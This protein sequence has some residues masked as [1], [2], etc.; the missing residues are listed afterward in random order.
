MMQKMMLAEN[1]RDMVVMLHSFLVENKNGEQEVIKSR[2][3]DFATEKYT[4]IAR[5]VALPA[6]IAVKLILEGKIELKGVQIPVN[7][8]VY[9]P[10]LEELERQGISMTEE[11]R[12]PES[13]KLN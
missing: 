12:L 2:M 13:E 6:A 8:S 1:S 5:T 3:V 4:A 11:W 9:E 7:K 10:V